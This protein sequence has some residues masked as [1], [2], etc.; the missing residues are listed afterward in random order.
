MSNV[1]FLDKQ[2]VA[3]AGGGLDRITAQHEKGKLTARER[4]SQLTDPGSFMETDQL[5]VAHG[6]TAHTA[7]SYTDGV[8]TGFAT[9]DGRQVALYAQDFTQQGGSLGKQHAQK[10]VKIMDMAAKIGCPII[11]LID[12]GG[13]RIGEG[14]H[15]LA[16]YGDIFYR[17]VRYA[18]VVPQISLILGPCAGGAVYSPALTDFICTVQGIGQLFITGPNVIEQ[19][20]G[21]VI[22]KEDLGGA[23]VHSATSGVVHL[24]SQTEAECFAQV[25][26]LLGYLPSNYKSLPPLAP[27]T[28][29]REQAYLDRIVPP[30][31]TKSY[32]MQVLIQ[33]IIDDESFFELQSAF[34]PNIITGFAHLGGISVGIVANQPLVTAGAIDIQAS[35]KAA[36][37]INICNAYDIP[38]ISLVDVPGYLPGV[39]QEHGGIIRHGAKLLHAY[40]QATCPKITV[41]IRKSFGGAYIVMGS[42]QL[43]AD[44]VFAWPQAQIAVLGGASAVQILHRRELDKIVDDELRLLREQER[45]AEYTRDY[46]H[47]Y[48]AAGSGYIDAIIEPNQTRTQLIQAVRLLQNKV[49][50]TMEKRS[51]LWPV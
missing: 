26:H 9:I 6:T 22:S 4:I 10:I 33:A 49:E 7:T 47:P 2:A 32:D 28:S 18:G 24:V 46:L 50:K 45:I 31:H 16:G 44:L 42:K 48:E 5:A 19:V 27:E 1:P 41:I 21:E 3:H 38:V 8:I 14:I 15:A 30:E 20:T 43:G 51:G 35:C 13:A 11:G 12:S 36:R 23:Q 39:A 25:R 17:N 29:S 40:A 34:A 37:F